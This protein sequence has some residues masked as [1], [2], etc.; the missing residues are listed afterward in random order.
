MQEKLVNKFLIAI[1]Q[2]FGT[3]VFSFENY[4]YV[5]KGKSVA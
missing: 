2:M 3:L 4:Y 1:V 5:A